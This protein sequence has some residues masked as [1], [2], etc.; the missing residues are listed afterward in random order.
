[1]S[2]WETFGILFGLVFLIVLIKEAGK[3][4]PLGCGIILIIFL[5]FTIKTCREIDE[6]ERL[7]EQRSKEID[8][9]IKHEKL[10][11][12]LRKLEE[13]EKQDHSQ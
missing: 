5:V 7:E 4:Y 13:R 10:M 3:K 6:E 11:L 12:E 2:F 8:E 1:M 9:K